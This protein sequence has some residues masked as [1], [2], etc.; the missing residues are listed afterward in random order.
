MFKIMIMHNT[1]RILI[2]FIQIICMNKFKF[3]NEEFV[4]ALVFSFWDR[5]LH[6]IF[7][8]NICA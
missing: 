3:K 8:F 4:K 6:N 7:N 2:L 5:I 1:F